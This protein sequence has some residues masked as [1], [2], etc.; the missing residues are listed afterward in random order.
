[1]SLFDDFLEST[2]SHTTIT[3]GDLSKNEQAIDV[4]STPKNTK[5]KIEYR[6]GDCVLILKSE[7]D[8]IRSSKFT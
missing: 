7:K 8:R 5:V 2:E 6:N 4:S 1:M 3:N